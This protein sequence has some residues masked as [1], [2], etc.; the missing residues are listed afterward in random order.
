MA[1][2]RRRR[3]IWRSAWL[4]L[5]QLALAQEQCLQ[6][7]WWQRDR[8]PCSCA[9][10]DALGALEPRFSAAVVRAAVTGRRRLVCPPGTVLVDSWIERRDITNGSERWGDLVAP[11]PARVDA[12]FGRQVCELPECAGSLSESL[13]VADDGTP[14][15]ASSAFSA[16]IAASCARLQP[17][18]S[19][20]AAA[21]VEPAPAPVGVPKAVLADVAAARGT[22]AAAADDDDDDDERAGATDH[23]I[24][25]EEWKAKM[26]AKIAE[27]P[28]RES[29]E[30]EAA[31]L[32]EAAASGQAPSQ[33]NS[34]SAPKHAPHLASE[35]ASFA[36][37]SGLR[38]PLSQRFNYGAFD[39][40]ARLVQANPE[41][42]GSGA[43]LKGDKDAYV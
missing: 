27:Q 39:A 13:S 30:A 40:G 1:L 15:V 25:L 14:H 28:A 36:S 35:G 8:T 32:A 9:A 38:P 42:K 26:L 29:A 33:P 12:C 41:A 31:M 17:D 19:P 22:A 3:R 11:A 34:S 23:I 6:P 4:L 21:P 18:G 20:L 7:A 37:P 10:D 5:A 43:I 2:A 16:A 24:P